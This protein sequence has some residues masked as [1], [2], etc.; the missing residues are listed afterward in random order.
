MNVL[1]LVGAGAS[2]ELGVPTMSG[3]AEE[4]A[5][6]TKQWNVEPALVEKLLGESNDIEHLIERL[7]Q[8]CTARDSLEAI[9]QD[10]EALDHADTIRAEVEWFVQHAVERVVPREAQLLWGAVLRASA[11]MKLTIVSTNYDRAI[12]LAAN[13]EGVQID[14]GFSQFRAD[15]TAV[16]RGFMDGSQATRVVKLHGSTDWYLDSNN[17]DPRKLRHPMPLFGKATLRL[18]N[19]LE[20]G[21]ALILPSREK[22][23]TREPYPRLSQAFLNAADQ[24][25]MAVVVGSSLRDPHLQSAVKT[26]ANHAPVF[27]V[28][29]NGS[30]LG[31]ENAIA[32]QQTASVF[33]TGTLPL[34]MRCPN[35]D[36][37][38]RSASAETPS[39]SINCLPPL[40]QAMDTEAADKIRCAALD[41]LEAAGVTLSTERLCALV[42]DASPE[43]AR[44]S[45]GFLGQGPDAAKLLRIAKSS[46]HAK[47]GTPFQDDLQLLQSM[48]GLSGEIAAAD[49]SAPSAAS[50]VRNP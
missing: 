30:T 26:I 35:P 22:L 5:E 44:Y 28:N 13:A 15:E 29:R 2:F 37:A 16:W 17:Y 20:L 48:L 42:K 47:D 45:L 34:A 27:L 38:L 24:C 50:F 10:R 41:Q 25:E 18:A 33:L 43:V 46:V 4:F 39:Q 36:H 7:D 9:G 14:D 31:I 12:E 32:L 23:L 3:L 21:S 6:H 1:V 11:R 40:A 8:I 49:Q 19:G